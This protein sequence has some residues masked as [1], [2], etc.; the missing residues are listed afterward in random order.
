MHSR[1]ARTWTAWIACAAIWL[2]ALAPALAQASG[3]HGPSRWIELCTGAGM[4]LVAVDAHGQPAPA[5]TGQA[6]A[7]PME[8]C[9][10]CIGGPAGL[11][12]PG[13][14]GLPSPAVAASRDAAAVAASPVP[15]RDGWPGAFPRGPPASV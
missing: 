8:P 1:R 12:P 3:G 15:S 14:T 6:G 2:G 10:V 7:A 9:A 5:G 13:T 4:R 11:L